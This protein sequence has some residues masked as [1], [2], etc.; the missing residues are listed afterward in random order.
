MN[1]KTQAVSDPENNLP[2]PVNFH[3]RTGHS[4]PLQDNTLQHEVWKLQKFSKDHSMVINQ[5][6]TKVAIFN[7]LK[8]TDKM[9][10]ISLQQGS[11]NIEVVEKFKLLGQIISTDLKTLSN[12]LN[13]CQKAFGKMWMLRR[14][15]ELGCPRLELLDV[16]KQQIL[17][18]V[19]QAVPHWAPMITQH[20]SQLIER[21]LK[22]ALHIILQEEY[23]S[24]HQALKL[25]H[26]KSLSLR[27]KEIFYKFCKNAEKSE[28][29]SKW[30]SKSV[31][32]R[33]TRR[34]LPQYN[35]VS[36]HTNRYER[37]SIPAMTKVLS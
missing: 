5:E 10:E 4:L 6:K 26:M 1:L 16:L 3:C 7:T 2:K 20:E 31:I 18:I 23:I 25:T 9:P 28:V 14:L 29:F 13:I 35:Q 17:S 19:E 8:N 12:T 37:S 24:F 30:F 36:C 33:Q 27:R 34:T 22:T 11:S 15:K 32:T 21:I